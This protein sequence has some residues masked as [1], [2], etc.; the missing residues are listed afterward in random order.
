MD[1]AIRTHRTVFPQAPPPPSSSADLL[2]TAP[3]AAARSRAVEL[4]V[5]HPFRSTLAR[6]LGV[7]RPEHSWQAGARGEELVARELAR[8]GHPW[9]VLHSVPVGRRGSDIDH[10]VLGPAG[11]FT[12]N[13]KHH[14]G[15]RIRVDGDRVW[16]NGQY[17][18]YVRNSRHEAN[19]AARL[20]S[21]A[22]GFPVPAQG[23]VVPVGA[24]AFDV[25]R[26]PVD[27][28][29]VN[30]ARIRRWL[31][32]Q[33]RVWSDAQLALVVQVAR[34]SATWVR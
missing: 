7:R 27:V 18:H 11:V 22:V 8:L 19:R 25:R 13:S 28:Q 5:G 20:L 23:V 33:P 3:G 16:V 29:V 15:A 4:T 24:A 6:F 21:A 10:V 1:E 32:G 34:S 17:Q 31:S 12:L 26:Q 14:R 9:T 30:R 2:L